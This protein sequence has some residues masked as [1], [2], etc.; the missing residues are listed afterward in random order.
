MVFQKLAMRYSRMFE[1]H[2]YDMQ[3]IYDPPYTF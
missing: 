3:D 2:I 1:A